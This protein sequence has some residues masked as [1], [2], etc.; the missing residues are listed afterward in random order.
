LKKKYSVF[1]EIQSYREQLELKHL[2]SQNILVSLSVFLLMILT[3]VYMIIAKYPFVTVF[4]FTIGY[5]V[6]L[7]FNFA[8]AAYAVDHFYYLKLNKYLTSLSLFTLIITLIIYFKSPSFIPL[9]FVAYA[10]CSIYKDIKILLGITLYFVFSIIMIT[11]S[12]DNIF[13]FQTPLAF[14]HLSIGFFVFLFL[15]ILLISSFIIVKEKTF[16]YNNIAFAKEKEYRNLNLLLEFD[17]KLKEKSYKKDY[18]YDKS[19]EFLLKLSNDLN[20]K[21]DFTEKIDIIQLL[22]QGV[23]KNTLLKQF[24]NF[25]LED[26]NRLQKLTIN[27]QSELRRLM[28]KIKHSQLKKLKQREIFSATHF[29]SFNKQTDTLDVKILCFAVF[30]VSLKKGLPGMKIISD[31]EIY[32]TIIN[33]N[34]YYFFDAKVLKIYQENPKVFET[35]IN[36]AIPSGGVI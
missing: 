2:R 18:Y 36:D 5:F 35:I 25:N 16:F 34:L 26:I 33:S 10:I 13:E 21:D 20:I 28:V 12:Y 1:S 30:L 31:E 15:A 32:D 3:F 7:L 24:P 27:S 22:D 14:K 29:Q 8:F 9:L 17:N 23:E 11:L 6:I 19:K 4:G